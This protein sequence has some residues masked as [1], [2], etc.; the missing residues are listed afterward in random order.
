M[1]GLSINERILKVLETEEL[2]TT[3]IAEKIGIEKE[4]LWSYISILLKREKIIKINDKKP[5][6][7]TSITPEAVVYRLYSMMTTKMKAKEKL[8]E[9]E[10]RFV[11]IIE[12]MIKNG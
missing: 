7:Y 12:E 10:L 5:Y 6:I 9:I 4:K 1:N 8:N 11:D 2:T 3:E